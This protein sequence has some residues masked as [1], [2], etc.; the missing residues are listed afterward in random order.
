M[1]ADYTRASTGDQILGFPKALSKAGCEPPFTDVLFEVKSEQRG[2]MRKADATSN[3][4]A[5]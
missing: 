3:A 1:L 5:A 4:R 2:L